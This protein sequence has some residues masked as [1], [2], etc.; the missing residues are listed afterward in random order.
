VYEQQLMPKNTTNNLIM[1][2]VITLV[3]CNSATDYDILI[4]GGRIYDGS[5][6]G[7]YI[8]DIAIKDGRIAAIDD[9]T[10][11]AAVIIDGD[12]LYVAPGFIDVHN[13]AEFPPE[14]P[15]RNT[16]MSFL[17][18]GVTTVVAGP[19]GGGE[20]KVAELFERLERDGVGPNVMHTVGH[21]YVRE[22][23]MGGSFDRPPTADEMNQMKQ[24]VREAMEGGAVGLSSGLYYVPGTYATTEEVVELARVVGEFGGI[25]TSHIRDE[26]D[27]I[28]EDPEK[29]GLLDAVREAILIGREAG[30][31][32]N[33]THI[34][35]EGILGENYWGKSVPV[36]ALIEEARARGQKVYADQYP[37]TASSTNLASV[38]VPRWVQ[39]D[40]MMTERLQDTALL[41]RI[42]GEMTRMVEGGLGPEVMVVSGFDE[43]PDWEGKSVAE[44]SRILEISPTEAAIELV[45]MGDPSIVVH[46]MSPDDVE[47][48]MSKP[49]ISTSSD[50]GNPVFGDGL[51]HPRS[52][53]AF[54]HKIREYV[55]DN[56]IIPMEF[57][58]R[59]ATSLPA[60][61]LG[62]QDRG[63]IKEDFVAD[64]VVFDPD[65]FRD[66]ATFSEPH[67]FSVG[68]NYLI[69]NGQIV[70]NH[71]EFTGTL[72]GRPLKSTLPPTEVH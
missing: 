13:H 43:R 51:P 48:F 50:G 59:A 20:Y 44:I 63:L 4:N 54:P 17:R 57:A 23:V 56:H 11:T 71:D 12:G 30:I 22:L 68:V 10:E 65:E 67:Q 55:L 69:I 3:A 41:P 28:Y 15:H 37:Y 72:A 29:D 32:A 19:D 38:T 47:R 42:T 36:T 26:G 46:S 40:G 1:V 7:S 49:Y 31:T 64:I 39:A 33:I 5:G 34:K 58:I 24:M 16:V 18:Q 61:V 62:L 6:E 9:L 52:Y 8:T 70:I 60:E 66:L 2:L 53:G 21:N 25:Y 27:F 35:A 14:D 45:L